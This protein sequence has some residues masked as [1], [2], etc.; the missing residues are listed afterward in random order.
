MTPVYLR[1]FWGVYLTAVA[2]RGA[3]KGT[4]LNLWRPTSK[5]QAG[6]KNVRHRKL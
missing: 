1:V 3:E 4:G 6:R 2:V 5:D